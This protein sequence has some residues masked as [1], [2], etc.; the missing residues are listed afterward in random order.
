MMD[1]GWWRSG[2][3]IYKS[4]LEKSC[5]QSFV[6]RLDVTEFKISDSQKKVLKVFNKYLLY[7]VEKK[8]NKNTKKIQDN[9]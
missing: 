4:D 8:I 3:Y 5:C 7:G 2:N 1:I 9:L 6:I